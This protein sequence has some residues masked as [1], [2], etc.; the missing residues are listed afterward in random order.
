M[1]NQILYGPPGTGKT[2]RL[3]ELVGEHLNRSRGRVLFSSHTRAAAQ[4]AASRFASPHHQSRIDIQTMHSLCFRNMK[5]SRAQ[6]VDRDKLEA[7]GEE[8]GIDMSE[9]GIGSEFI[10]VLSLSR[11]RCVSVDEG[12]QMSWRPGTQQ[13]YDA[14]CKSYAQ[15][16]QTFGYMDFDDM[17]FTG[18]VKLRDA[19]YSLIAI[20]EA[21]DLTPLHWRVIQRL[22]ELN[23]QAQFL[24]AGDDDQAIYGFAGADPLGMRAFGEKT[25]A[26]S[27]VLEQS[28]RITKQVH[29]L[30]QAIIARVSDRV[31]K[32]YF[33]RKTED[34]Q[35]AQGLLEMHPHMDYMIPNNQRDSLILYADRFVRQEVEPL[36]QDNGFHY[37][38]LNGWPSPEDTRAGRAIRATLVHSD[39]EIMESD[40]L[41][42]TIR[43]GLSTKGVSAW[44]NVSPFEVTARIRRGD[45]GVLAVKRD[46]EDYL[47]ALDYAEPQNI[48]IS[49]M[50]GA[51]GL[52][53][54]DVHL[55]LSLS[56]RA[57]IE[58]AINP[59]NLHRLL[60][61]AV[62]RARENLYLYDGEN[63]YDLPMSYGESKSMDTRQF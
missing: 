60:Y 35:D 48:R 38:A 45:W 28:Y 17:L 42:S 43:S 20:D 33:P 26:E 11:A 63:G 15:W 54:D 39:D 18:A 19:H 41:R 13:H 34:G 7:F 32:Q 57:Q 59:D 56:P 50:H 12:Y 27:T 29:T 24:I 9:E 55:I 6:T 52:Q 47:R 25:G 30:A 3:L 23:P 46:H 1:K 22:V 14:F 8:F 62:T 16:K 10:E 40:D 5:L 4:E 61:T 53:A 51:K 36:L 21:Q 58:G 31:P 37:K 44:D 49:T 2:R